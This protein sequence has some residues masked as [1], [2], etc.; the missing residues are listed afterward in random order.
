MAGEKGSDVWP[1]GR[2]ILM[3]AALATAAWA[4]IGTGIY[5]VSSIE[6]PGQ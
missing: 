3:W 6:V 1:M 5:F 4:V 2:A